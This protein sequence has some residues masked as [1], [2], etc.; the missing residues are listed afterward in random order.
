MGSPRSPVWSLPRPARHLD[1][2]LRR[3]P[4]IVVHVVS[5]VGWGK[6]LIAVER[7]MKGIVLLEAGWLVGKTKIDD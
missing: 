5:S 3:C 4:R 2:R 1:S 6:G 7:G